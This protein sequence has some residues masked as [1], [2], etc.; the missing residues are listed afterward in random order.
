MDL[1][2]IFYPK[3]IAIIG[4]STEVG[5]VGNDIVKNLI[6]QGY[7]GKIFPVNPKATEL[8]DLKCYPFVLAIKEKV[9]LAIIVVPSGIVP[10]VL[11]TVAKKKIKGVIII[12]AGFKEVGNVGLE[13]Q[14]KKICQKNNI[15][16]VG[17]NCLGIINP[18]NK[19]N[20][21]FAN[22]MPPLGNIAFISQS[23]ALCTAI[24][25]YAQKL[26]IGFSKFVSVGNKAL[27][28]EADLFEYLAKDKKTKVIAMYVEELT[29]AP[30]IIAAAKKL[31]HGKN[32]KPI[33][34]IKSG[35]TSDGASASASHTGALAGN[36]SAYQ[37]LF[38]QA[39]IIRAEKISEL[40][41]YLRI[42]T[43]NKL[44][45]G[46]HVAIITNAGG[47][48]VLTTDE[49]VLSGL[50]MAKISEVT[51]KKLRKV[52]PA[53]ANFH[54][55]IDV[56]GDAKAERYKAVIDILE[57]DKNVD[58]II[59][60]LT[61]QSMTE[62]DLTA[63][64]IINAKKKSK[65]PIVASFIGG[66]LVEKSIKMLRANGVSTFN[67]PEEAAKALDAL[68]H[69]A[70]IRKDKCNTKFNL[71]NTNKKAAEKYFIEAKKRGQTIFPEADAL[72]ILRDYGFTLLLSEV[73]KTASEAEKI[74]KK[75]G[76]P[77]VLK[78]VS[79]NILHKT[80]AGGVMLN[81]A[82][83]EAGTKFTEMIK[84]IKHKFPLAKIDGIL[85]M[86]MIK[87][88]GVEMILGSVK[89]QGL[90]NTIMVGLGG[91]YVEIFRDVT[92]GL[93]PLTAYDAQKMINKLKSKKILDGARGQA[94]MDTQALIDCLGRLSQL[95]ID[96]PNIKELDINPL[97]VLPKGR[98]V[99]VLDARIVIE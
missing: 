3:S 86:E 62:F 28:S 81:V 4:A 63:Q 50:Q 56:L 85:I 52:L 22:I 54:N 61:P 18:E 55:P 77:V 47:P 5:H 15:A 93:A 2:S 8:Y 29:N 9:D 27:L 72:P 19:M 24:L 70:N 43:H 90:G 1:N 23:G 57:K 95:L 34:A 10:T 76:Q 88:K 64:A 97:L 53:Y 73:A 67:F 33:I 32:P 87:E 42:F 25:D 16:L 75:I 46:G 6:T 26:D 14:I 98:G 7:K 78:I 45:K 58:S 74:A 20:A 51:E 49:V 38:S 37:G 12:S 59:V 83:N 92:F 80:D 89:D 40:F 31:T 99:K 79:Q 68:T 21:S 13:N 60:V 71:K 39:G 30:A 36:D 41:E 96:F 17:P 91:T 94:I 44:P 65:K 69:F 84:N 66:K 11:E 48:G 35:R 82:P